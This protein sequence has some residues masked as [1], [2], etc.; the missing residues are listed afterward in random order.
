MEVVSGAGFEPPEGAEPMISAVRK[1][2]R[3][4]FPV[5]NRYSLA[6]TELQMLQADVASLKGD[7]DCVLL[8]MPGGLRRGGNFF[9]QLLGV[10]DSALLMTGFDRTPRS[11]LA[12]VRRHVVAAEKPMMGLVVGASAADVRREMEKRR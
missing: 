4:W 12:Y 8:T 10:C 9:D 2:A 3:G 5:V 1:G 6:P 7:F 11:A